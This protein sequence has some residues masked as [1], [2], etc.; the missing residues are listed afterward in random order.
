MQDMGGK[1]RSIDVDR[2]AFARQGAAETRAML[3]A[4]GLRT[5]GEGEV[6]KC[7]KGADP[8]AD[9]RET[10]ITDAWSGLAGWRS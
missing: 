4:A 6:V 2:S 8:Q 9:Q 3:F 10:I 5:E 1:R 7:L